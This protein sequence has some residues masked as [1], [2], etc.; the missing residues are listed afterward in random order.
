[1]KLPVS[2][3]EPPPEDSPRPEKAATAAVARIDDSDPRRANAQARRSIA[4]GAGGLS[5]VF[6]EATTALGKGLPAREETIATVLDGIA[7][8]GLTLRMDA[9]PASRLAAGWLVSHLTARKADPA[10]LSL[11]LGIDPAAV[12]ARAGRLNM[13]VEALKASMP[14]SLVHF[15]AMGVPGVLL[16]ADGRV[17][18]NAGATPA[19]EI[20]A[21]LA[22]ASGHL[23]LFEQA[24]QALVYAAPHIGFALGAE[25]DGTAF[26]AKAEAVR[27]LWAQMLAGRSIEPGAVHIHAETAPGLPATPATLAGAGVAGHAGSLSVAAE[28]G[29]EALRLAL[30]LAG[31]PPQAQPGES[32]EAQ[33]ESLCEAG[34]A[35]FLAIEREGGILDS[36]AA[37][38][39]Q[40]RIFAAAGRAAPE[41]TPCAAGDG[42]TCVPLEPHA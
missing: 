18:H 31:R 2:G 21:A 35:E 29:D 28:D 3:I 27:R 30:V 15:F 14:Q 39:L 8:D 38:L 17:F 42:A 22:I 12:F 26:A 20:G 11:S 6:E 33:V 25:A 40:G 24:R 7:L 9:H 23:K 13:S 32:F 4:G 37:G 34:R 41:I 36:L 5:L 16:E 19:Q 10:R 1:M